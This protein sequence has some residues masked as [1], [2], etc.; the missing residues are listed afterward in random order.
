VPTNV[1]IE[2]KQKMSQLWKSYELTWPVPALTTG[3]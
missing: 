2:L 3:V 1:A